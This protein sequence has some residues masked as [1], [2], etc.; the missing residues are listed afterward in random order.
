MKGVPTLVTN[1]RTISCY[2]AIGI[3]T[4]TLTVPKVLHDGRCRLSHGL[5][6]LPRTSLSCRFCLSPPR[7]TPI[8]QNEYVVGV[9]GDVSFLFC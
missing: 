5:R 9:T 7:T 3:N 8:D 1:N 4:Y 2:A 6:L